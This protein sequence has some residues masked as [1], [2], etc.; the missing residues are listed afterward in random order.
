MQLISKDFRNKAW[1]ALSGRWGFM[2]GVTLIHGLLSTLVSAVP[3]IGPI[4]SLFVTGPL[5]F[6]FIF[7]STKINRNEFSRTN[8]LFCGFE[9]FGETFL[10]HLINSLLIF[11]WTLLL[12]VPGIIKSCAYSMSYYILADNPNLTHNEARQ[13]SEQLMNGHKFR[14]FCLELSFIGWYLLATLTAGILL[15]WVIPYNQVAVAAFYDDL[16]SNN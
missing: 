13:Q 8:D 15:F 10:L 16:I 5:I 7:I 3:Y 4:A 9:N 11:L 14:Y 2:A 12:I 1:S 6:G